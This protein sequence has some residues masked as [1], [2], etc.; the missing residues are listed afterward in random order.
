M[1]D[2]GDL[3]TRLPSVSVSSQKKEWSLQPLLSS[4]WREW[5]FLKF[6]SKRC[7]TILSFKKIFVF[8][9]T[10]QTVLS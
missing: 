3:K 2:S 7:R 10:A 8:V 4:G 1:I 5:S 6:M 9:T